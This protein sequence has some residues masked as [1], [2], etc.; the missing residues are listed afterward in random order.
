[1]ADFDAIYEDIQD[2]EPLPMPILKIEPILIR[3]TGNMTVYVLAI[4]KQPT[5]FCV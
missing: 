5:F 3:G 2:E 4:T 1:M